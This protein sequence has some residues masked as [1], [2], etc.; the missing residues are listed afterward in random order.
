[1]KRI[2]PLWFKNWN[3]SRGIYN[4]H[5]L[6]GFNRITDAYTHYIRVTNTDEQKTLAGSSAYTPVCVSH[7]SRMCSSI[8]TYVYAGRC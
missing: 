8:H 7:R 1:M 5:H 3:M 4:P 6:H 2:L